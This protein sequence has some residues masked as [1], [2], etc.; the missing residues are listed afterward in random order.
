MNS[1]HIVNVL[2]FLFVLFKIVIR[3]LIESFST[4]KHQEGIPE[5]SKFILKKELH[6][7]IIKSL[8]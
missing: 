7:G 2:M 3:F 5:K 4:P 8:F 6:I 1:V